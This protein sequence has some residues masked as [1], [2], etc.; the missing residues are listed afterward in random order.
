[1][2]GGGIQTTGQH[3]EDSARLLIS[4]QAKIDLI[5]QK[6]FR[7]YLQILSTCVIMRISIENDLEKVMAWKLTVSSKEILPIITEILEYFF[8]N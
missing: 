8:C 4:P 6:E 5:F 2:L 3:R 1:M 7:F